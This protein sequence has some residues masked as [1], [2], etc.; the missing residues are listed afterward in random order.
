M[1]FKTQKSEFVEI[2]IPGVAAGQTGT[3]WYFP[4][5]PKLRYV[6]VQAIETYTNEDLTNTMQGNAVITPTI[7]RN[8]YLSLYA[9]ERQDLWRI[10]LPAL[11]RTQSSATSTF[12]RSLFELT[13]QKVTWDKSYV[14]LAAAPANI[15]NLA[16][17]FQ[18]YYS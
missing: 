17:C 3:R 8:A 16:I 2:Q 12:V 13:G 10:P 1:A 11:H 15:T 9:N 5:L 18:V 6:S 4:D 7:F 14:E